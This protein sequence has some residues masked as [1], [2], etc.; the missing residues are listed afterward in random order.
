VV[1]ATTARLAAEA[2]KAEILAMLDELGERMEG[3]SLPDG[4]TGT[5]R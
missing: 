4:V 5:P 3:L 1:D 2:E